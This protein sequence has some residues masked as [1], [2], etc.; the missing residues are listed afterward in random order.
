MLSFRYTA[1]LKNILQ[2]LLWAFQIQ[3]PNAPSGCKVQ[4]QYFNMWNSIKNQTK[5]DLIAN[6]HT[7]H[8]IIT[9]ISLGGGLAS[10]SYGDINAMKIFDKIEI[11]TYGAPRVGNEKW[12]KWLESQ[13]DPD[14]LHICIKGDPICVLPRCLTPICNYKHSG[15]GYSCDKNDEVCRPVG[16]VGFE[17][18]STQLEALVSNVI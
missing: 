13:V 7:K 18:D 9:G 3:D 14:P 5:N 2:D 17:W 6:S 11:I 15:V 4:K 12:A 8:L 1:T 16:R 10:I